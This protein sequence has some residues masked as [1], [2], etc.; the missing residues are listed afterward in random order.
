MTTA[1]NAAIF[2]AGLNKRYESIDGA[3]LIDALVHQEFQGRIAVLSSFG[4]ES[5]ALLSLVAEVDPSLPVITLDTGKLFEETIA[6]R[7]TLIRRLGLRDV[8]IVRPAASTVAAEDSDGML[9]YWD[10]DRCCG[11]RKVSPMAGALAAFDAVISGR[12]RYHGEMRSFLPLF[13]AV[14]GQIKVDPLARWSPTQVET[15]FAARALPRHPLVARG[16]KSVGCEPCT[17][18]VEGDDIR[19]G[20]WA[21][22]MKTECGIHLAA[23]PAAA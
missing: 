13:E 11:M 17:I 2:A 12:K 21:G 8:R 14:D 16:Y 7:E 4:S 22:R 23:K 1:D 5:A 6:Y 3:A 9:W 19:A 10:P 15:L 18:P 20:R